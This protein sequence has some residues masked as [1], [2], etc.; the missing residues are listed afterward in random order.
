MKVFSIWGGIPQGSILG[1]LLFYIY[2]NDT[3][4]IDES[5]R[6]VM[7]ADN[8]TLYFLENTI[9]RFETKA[10]NVLALRKSWSLAKSLNI[11]VSKTKTVLF[12]PRNKNV[13]LPLSLTLSTYNIELVSTVK[14]LGVIFNELISWNSHVESVC[15]MLSCTVGA[16]FCMC[17]GLPKNMEIFIYN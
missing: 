17:S 1:P 8:I 6:Y 9:L 16:L 12:R 5:C 4:H 10:S 15:H 2:V 14:F 11:N 3:A 7:Y 13:D